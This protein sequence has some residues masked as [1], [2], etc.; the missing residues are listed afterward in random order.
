M[1]NKIYFIKEESPLNPG[2]WVISPVHE[3]FYLIYTAGSFNIIS[4][5]VL[6]L[7][8]AQYLRF[9]RDLCRGEIVG[10]N[11]KYPIVYFNNDEYLNVLV[12]LLNT[13][14]KLIIWEREHPQI[15]DC[16]ST[17]EVKQIVEA[18]KKNVNN[19]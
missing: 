11:T 1:D 2:K 17:L 9:C 14:A 8:Y 7:T 6:G 4:A 3:N 15:Q 19:K 10:K 5:R 12:R 16:K 13:C 18:M